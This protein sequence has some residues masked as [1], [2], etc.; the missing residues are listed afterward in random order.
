MASVTE[1]RQ[2]EGSSTFLALEYNVPNTLGLKEQT[3]GVRV[4]GPETAGRKNEE[5]TPCVPTALLQTP[6]TIVEIEEEEEDPR[7]NEEQGASDAVKPPDVDAVKQP[8]GDTVKLPDVGA[9]ETDGDAGRVESAW[10]KLQAFVEDLFSD[11]VSHVR[12]SYVA[13]E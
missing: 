11:K 12:P 1:K 10:S 5:S 2:S 4:Q 6:P 9:Q 13:R 7:H 3:G 8:A